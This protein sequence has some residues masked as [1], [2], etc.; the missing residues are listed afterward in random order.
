MEAQIVEVDKEQDETL[1]LIASEK[2]EHVFGANTLKA[3]RKVT[4]DIMG[5][6]TDELKDKGSLTLTD[7][8]LRIRLQYCFAKAIK[9]KTKVRDV[10]VYTGITTGT[11]YYR[12][13]LANPYKTAYALQPI[14]QYER[15]MEAMLESAVNRYKDLINMDIT[16]PRVVYTLNSEGKRVPKEIIDIDPKKAMVLLNVIKSVEERVKGSVIQKNLNINTSEPAPE[17]GEVV[18]IDHDAV[19]MRLAELERKL[20]PFKEVIDVTPT[21]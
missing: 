9:N 19:D 17:S 10:D 16:T 14:I 2:A 18:S 6:G 3:L 11:Y 1:A 20:N 8:Q 13:F 4:P 5:L 12:S 21:R 15:K 7:E